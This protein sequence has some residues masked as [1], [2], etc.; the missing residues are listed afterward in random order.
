MAK[1]K[2]PIDILKTNIQITEKK[3]SMVTSQDINVNVNV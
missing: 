2:T 3:G 1:N